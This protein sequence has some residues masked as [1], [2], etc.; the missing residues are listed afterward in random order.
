MRRQKFTALIAAA[1]L[2]IAGC[3]GGPVEK[4]PRPVSTSL[5][6]ELFQLPRGAVWSVGAGDVAY[7]TVGAEGG[8]AATP[9]L[10]VYRI[11]ERYEELGALEIYSGAASRP[12]GPLGDRYLVQR[13]DEAGSV[14]YLAIDRYRNAEAIASDA[15]GLA[16]ALAFL[17]ATEASN[18]VV[19]AGSLAFIVPEYATTPLESGAYL[20]SESLTLTR[21]S[22]E[23]A[24]SKAGATSV[25]SLFVEGGALYLAG[26]RLPAASDDGTPAEGYLARFSSAERADWVTVLPGG[27]R[28]GGIAGHA[29]TSERLALLYRT[30]TQIT[31]SSCTRE[32]C[33][34]IASVDPLSGELLAGIALADDFAYGEYAPDAI[35]DPFGAAK[36]LTLPAGL[37][38]TQG[39]LLLT[40]DRAGAVSLRLADLSIVERDGADQVEL[41]LRSAGDGE[42]APLLPAQVGALR[43]TL[44]FAD[45]DGA[46]RQI[47]VDL[48]DGETVALGSLVETERS[49]VEIHPAGPLLWVGLAGPT[50]SDWLGFRRLTVSAE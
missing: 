35:G 42:L 40:L 2:S 44:F 12:I 7:A 20:L 11:D 3:G 24:T 28:A 21:L 13:T 45:A 49:V 50:E 26:K 19:F 38:D 43:R 4:S 36:A 47:T 39:L 9:L 15:D 22:P 8:D 48:V 17:A 10:L 41:T 1:L 32:T 6:E 25:E 29:S 30:D 31:G 46:L 5:S 27:L 14:G 18:R 37:A 34:A 23:D 33:L 16:D